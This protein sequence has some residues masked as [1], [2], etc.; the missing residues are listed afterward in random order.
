MAQQKTSPRD[1]FLHLLGAVTLY[2]SAVAI[3]TI[4]FQYV[5][6]FFPDVI[7]NYGYRSIPFD[8]GSARAAISTLIVAFPIFAWIT[9]FLNKQYKK[10]PALKELWVRRWLSY[11]TIFIASIILIVTLIRVIDTFLAGELTM[12]FF[13][14]MGSVFA[15]ALCVFYY[16]ISDIRDTLSEAIRKAYVWGTPI[17]LVIMIV[18]GVLIAG[19]PSEQ[20]LQNIDEERVRDLQEITNHI[21]AYYEQKMSL[22]MSLDDVEGFRRTTEVPFGVTFVPTD[23]VTEESYA[24]DAIDEE[25]YRLCA[26]FAT[27][28][29]ETMAEATLSVYEKEWL[30]KSDT[31]CF[32]RTV[33]KPDVTTKPLLP[34]FQE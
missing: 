17:L 18:G 7:S 33:E 27:D 30:H 14:R 23:P 31:Q 32:E 16:Y 2:M 8:N 22:P 20:R 12:R 5:D 15:V 13:L 19:S 1:F 26:T 6:H 21:N 10:T 34:E 9:S 28:S 3:M 24:Y 29:F 4:L 11:F 25:T